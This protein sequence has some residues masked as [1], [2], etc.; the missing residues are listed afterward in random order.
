MIVE[1]L[2][3]KCLNY[4]MDLYVVP[5]VAIQYL[6]AFI[7][8]ANIGRQPRSPCLDQIITLKLFTLQAMPR[9]PGSRRILG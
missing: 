5:I 3:L 8:R 9:S 6:F 4:Q 7:D 2:Q 1:S